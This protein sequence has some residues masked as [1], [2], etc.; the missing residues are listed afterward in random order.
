MNLRPLVDFDSIVYKCAWKND[1]DQALEK[2]QSY[3][4][5]IE[6]LFSNKAE[7]FLSGGDNFRHSVDPNY[8][9]SRKDKPKPPFYYEIREHFIGLGAFV[10]CGYEADD[11]VGIRACPEAIVC[12]IDKDLNTIPG[13]H[14]N[15]DKGSIYE[16][17]ED[18]AAK[19]FWIQ[20]LSGDSGDD[21][22]GL[23]KIGITKATKLLEGIDVK[24]Y[25]KTVEAKYLEVLGSDGFIEFDK[26]ARLV[27]IKRLSLETEYYHIYP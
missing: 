1:L 3:I 12:G 4:N 2:G 19:T 18:E 8:K 20:V 6:E 5:I 16:I 13:W 7:I 11:E 22:K 26:T 9:I 24:D 25:R 17:S 23:P 21:I 27:F 14:Y 10:S 15:Y